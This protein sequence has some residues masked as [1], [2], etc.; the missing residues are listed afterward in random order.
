MECF[1]MHNT[2]MSHGG[3]QN[4]AHFSR[5]K[6]KRR[7][8]SVAKAEVGAEQASGSTGELII[9]Y[10]CPDCGRFHIGHADKA[11]L[12]ARNNLSAPVCT[13]CGQGIPRSEEPEANKSRS[14]AVY[15]S[16]TCRRAARKQRRETRFDEFPQWLDTVDG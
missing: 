5:C 12:L 14:D 9:A 16:E 1:L 6:G 11:Q 15:C 8:S 4:P 10:E 3:W 7:Y 13:H 2:C